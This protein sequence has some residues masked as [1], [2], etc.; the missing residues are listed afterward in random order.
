MPGIRA[1]M[2]EFKHGTLHSGSKHGPVVKSRKQAI[3]IGMSEARKGGS[4][5]HH[6]GHGKHGP[7]FGAAHNT[8]HHS[9]RHSSLRSADNPHSD[10]KQ[11]RGKPVVRG[12]M[13]PR[14]EP[15]AHN[16]VSTLHAPGSG[17][18]EHHPRAGS[19][20]KFEHPHSAHA[21]GFGHDE[22]QRRGVMRLSGHKGAHQ[23]GKR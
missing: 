9:L 13:N 16:G 18:A 7:A 3:A 22:H 23:V 1:T 8:D 17:K 15:A 6:G 12:D 21:H 19:P 20:H 2:H 5:K 10:A 4:K 11:P 14:G